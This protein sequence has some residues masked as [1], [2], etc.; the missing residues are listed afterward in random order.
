[1]PKSTKKPC[2]KEFNSWKRR[3]LCSSCR[4]L[5]G[6]TSPN[7]WRSQ[8]RERGLLCVWHNWCTHK[9]GIEDL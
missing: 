7:N 3:G 1:M 2:K 4:G 5:L 8:E 9:S 6:E